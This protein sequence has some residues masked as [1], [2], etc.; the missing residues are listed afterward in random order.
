MHSMLSISTDP[1]LRQLTSSATNC[2][3][4]S[5]DLSLTVCLVIISVAAL[6]LCWLCLCARNR[7]SARSRNLSR[8]VPLSATLSALLSSD[9]SRSGGAARRNSG[10][11]FI[12]GRK[13]SAARQRHA[14]PGDGRSHAQHPG[15][16]PRTCVGRLGVWACAYREHA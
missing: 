1:V 13:L 8:R 12:S 15:F 16:H 7:T 6:G 3:S 14:R 10:G 9:L 5:H 4:G 11:I 2:S